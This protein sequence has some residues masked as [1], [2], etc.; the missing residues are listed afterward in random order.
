M[1]GV[2][3]EKGEPET[4]HALRPLISRRMARDGRRRV[5][6]LSHIGY[7]EVQFGR[8]R[9]LGASVCEPFALRYVQR[10]RDILHDNGITWSTRVKAP[11]ES[12]AVDARIPT[13]EITCGNSEPVLFIRASATEVWRWTSS[14]DLERIKN[15]SFV[16]RWN[17]G[18]K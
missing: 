16:L 15:N 5:H 14:P 17:T 11:Y 18:S 13:A 8:R 6:I 9:T 2:T 10:D 1:R 12:T 4:N 3:R 7:R